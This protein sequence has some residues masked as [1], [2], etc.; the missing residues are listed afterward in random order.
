MEIQGSLMLLMGAVY[1]ALNYELELGDNLIVSF[2]DIAIMMET[3]GL[4]LTFIG[5]MFGKQDITSED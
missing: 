2:W 4:V 1:E 3:F 5:R